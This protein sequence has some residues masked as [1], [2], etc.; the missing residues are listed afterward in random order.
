MS[1]CPFTKNRLGQQWV[2]PG[3]GL[4]LE[5]EKNESVWQA[6]VRRFVKDLATNQCSDHAPKNRVDLRNKI[7]IFS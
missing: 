5:K 1:S 4:G 6:L 2:I 7:Q 3:V